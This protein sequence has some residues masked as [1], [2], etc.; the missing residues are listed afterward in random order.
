[1]IK[2]LYSYFQLKEN[3]TS[4]KKEVIAGFTTFI[5]MAYIIVV[6]PEMMAKTGM[7]KD[8]IFVGTC[9]A[10][11]LACIIMGLYANW[12]VG[13]AP[14]MGLNAFFTY[15]VVIQ[16]NYEWQVAL[17]AVFLA[18][19]LF[20]IMSITKLRSWMIDS[21]PFNLRIAMGAGVGLFIGFLGLQEGG[22]IDRKSVV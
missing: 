13:L 18:G 22:I 9:I 2:I 10:A 4:I 14:G 6:N 3:N 12:P 11:A 1:M 21:I 19:I 5:T 20:F 16:M 15:T 8:A 17:G 7:N